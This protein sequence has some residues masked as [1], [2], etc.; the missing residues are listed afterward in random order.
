MD[1]IARSHPR[2]EQRITAMA[3]YAAACVAFDRGIRDDTV[4]HFHDADLDA[5]VSVAVKRDLGDGA[6]GW[7][8]KG[9]A[10]SIAELVAATLSVR[11]FDSL[12]ARRVTRLITA[13]VT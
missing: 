12:P 7:G 2:V 8:R 11:A 9:S 6:F 13:P 3:E 1:A 4:H 10:G 5:A